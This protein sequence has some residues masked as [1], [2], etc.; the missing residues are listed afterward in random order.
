MRT[1]LKQG[2]PPCALDTTAAGALQRAPPKP[3]VRAPRSPAHA[4]PSRSH[5]ATVGS[6]APRRSARSSSRCR[7]HGKT[8][9]RRQDA[10]SGF[11]TPSAEEDRR[12]SK[13]PPAAAVP[14]RLLTTRWRPAPIEWH[15]ACPGAGAG[16]PSRPLGIPCPYKKRST[17]R[18]DPP[19]GSGHPAAVL[20]KRTHT[21]SHARA[22]P[23]PSRKT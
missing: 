15:A 22:S 1:P 5:R 18:A 10:R 2:N 13:P 8:C 17:T 9:K 6:G 12:F 19:S 3:P 14:P 20:V 7:T 4:A 23:H 16:M 21:H 11:V